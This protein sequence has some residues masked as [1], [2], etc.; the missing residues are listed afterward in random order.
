MAVTSSSLLNS[1]LASWSPSCRG[2]TLRLTSGGAVYTLQSEYTIN[3]ANITIDA[4]EASSPV[5][6]L[7]AP[8]RW[9]F[10]VRGTLT[11]RNVIFMPTAGPVVETIAQR[12]GSILVDGT[13]ALASFVDCTF[14][15]NYVLSYSLR[16]Y[17][18]GVYVAAGR[19]L[20]SGCYLIGNQAVSSVQA[21]GGAVYKAGGTVAMYDTSFLRNRAVGSGRGGAVY[22]AGSGSMTVDW[23]NF[24]RNY[25]DAGGG[26]LYVEAGSSGSVTRAWFTGNRNAATV[27]PSATPT[28]RPTT[29]PSASPTGQP[30]GS[31]TPS[32]SGMPTP[33]L[34][35]GETWEPT[36]SPSLAPTGLPTFINTS[37]PS[38]WLNLTANLTENVTDSSA[39]YDSWKDRA[40]LDDIYNLG[41]LTLCHVTSPR[42]SIAGVGTTACMQQPSTVPTT[43]PTTFP[44]FRPTTVS[45]LYCACA[46]WQ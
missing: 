10:T 29:D 1:V 24:T 38:S 30:T 15:N 35:G 22:T 31:P 8:A 13:T 14:R 44:T 9:H 12:G 20:L 5:T 46:S 25:A 17:G 40:S 43:Q 39:A 34:S 27:Q 32:P 18:G 16:T 45:W 4:A 42:A 41:T 2:V 7:S 23:V 28:V 26:A 21:N 11:A 19:V 3:T 37:S 33:G 36:S 6:I